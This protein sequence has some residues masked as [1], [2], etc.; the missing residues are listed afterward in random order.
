MD[1]HD[2]APRRTP[3][4]HVVLDVI[5]ASDG[6]LLERMDEPN[7]IVDAWRDIHARVLGGDADYFVTQIGFGESDAPPAAGN[8]AL[9]NPYVKPLSPV[10]PFPQRVRFTFS[11]TEGEANGLAIR[12]LGL[13]TANGLL[14]ARKVRAAALV[15]TSD[16]AINGAWTI[17]F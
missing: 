2:Q 9:T 10:Y 3:W 8:T 12:E 17:F 6:A 13:L 11:L 14:Y 15:K 5:R 7:V 16:I 1:F 4:G